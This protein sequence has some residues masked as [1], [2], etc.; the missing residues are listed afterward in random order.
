MGTTSWYDHWNRINYPAI[1]IK[2]NIA[3][4]GDGSW[5]S[6]ASL[7]LT[8]RSDY[9]WDTNNGQNYTA[10]LQFLADSGS[11]MKPLD[12]FQVETY[13]NMQANFSGG[14]YSTPEPSILVLFGIGVISLLGYSWRRR[15]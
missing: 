15:R 11:G 14:F 8:D 1:P 10:N 7:G 3:I 12:Q 6:A 13:G 5:V 9:L 4:T 2:L